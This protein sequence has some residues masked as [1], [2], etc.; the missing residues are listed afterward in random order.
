MRTPINK[1][2]H[3]VFTFPNNTIEPLPQVTES[4]IVATDNWLEKKFNDFL[5]SDSSSP[6][7]KTSSSKEDIYYDS[8]TSYIEKLCCGIN[9]RNKLLLK[10]CTECILHRNQIRYSLLDKTVIY[11]FNNFKYFT[12]KSISLGSKQFSDQTRNNIDSTDETK[13]YIFSKLCYIS[14]ELNK[15]I[16]L[17]WPQTSY[18]PE[19]RLDIL[20]I[21]L[22]PA[23]KILNPIV[24]DKLTYLFCS[25]GITE[26]SSQEKIDLLKK[27]LYE[28]NMFSISTEAEKNYYEKEP[29][30]QGKNLTGL[31][32]NNTLSDFIEAAFPKQ[33]HQEQR[34]ISQNFSHL[35]GDLPDILSK[36]E[37]T[38]VFKIA[39][40]ILSN[41]TIP[42]KL[43]PPTSDE[44]Q[45]IF[46]YHK[47]FFSQIPRKNVYYKALTN[48]NIWF[49]YI[50]NLASE[51]FLRKI[52]EAKKILTQNNLQQYTLYRNK[53]FSKISPHCFFN[54]LQFDQLTSHFLTLHEKYKSSTAA[55]QA[56]R[57]ILFNISVGNTETIDQLF[58][59]VGKIFLGRSIYQYCEQPAK[60]LTI[61]KC[62]NPTYIY[63]FL[64]QIFQ[65]ATVNVSS[66]P[67][68]TLTT[69]KI[70]NLIQDKLELTL[71]NI[72]YS[73]RKVSDTIFLKKLLSDNFVSTKDPLFGEIFHRNTLHYVYITDS[74]DT[75]NPLHS[76]SHNRINLTEDISTAIYEPLSEDE[77]FFFI[78]TSICKS[79]DKLFNSKP[80]FKNKPEVSTTFS[81]EE[82][83]YEFINKFCTDTTNKISNDEIDKIP[84]ATIS[85]SKNDNDRRSK[86][87]ELGVT[88]LAYT[89]NMDLTEGFSLWLKSV[90]DDTDLKINERKLAPIL[91]TKYH[92][93]FYIKVDNPT[94]IFRS[95]K[96][97]S[98]PK[99]FY[100]ISL[101]KNKLDAFLQE[102]ANEQ[103]QVLQKNLQDNFSNYLADHINKY[104][105][106]LNQFT[107]PADNAGNKYFNH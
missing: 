21:I 58:E 36:L 17:Y 18:L 69:E 14:F 65:F 99:A 83:L 56:L 9:C 87:I 54:N 63:S 8:I 40:L 86:A 76:L 74:S 16:D 102:K 44:F 72:D 24:F 33:S 35:L 22:C 15:L 53:I 90:S 91:L 42:F 11:E 5:L 84:L 85:G 1:K 95:E 77:I 66:Y 51:R 12:E 94:S 61:I 37:E 49:G 28:N 62:K 20:R 57:T 89:L 64:A 19:K 98:S 29:N 32:F 60:N 68:N 55:F 106:E 52:P 92:T 2:D 75:E 27:N 67:L 4:H 81:L 3:N 100:G 93:I 80:S 103:E 104:N 10:N 34:T 71:A 82:R 70:P 31:L 79:I 46:H 25:T 105:S 88:K 26:F 73:K 50:L 107:F 6:F 39:K 59:L 48:E 38:A 41:Q 23:Q 96:I 13:D 45:A 47:N 101:N 43:I 78:L 97:H 7:F 30:H